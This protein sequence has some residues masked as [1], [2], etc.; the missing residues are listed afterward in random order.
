[1]SKQPAHRPHRRFKN[2][3][4]VILA[5]EFEQCIHCGEALELSGRAGYRR[6]PPGLLSF[7]WSLILSG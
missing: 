7:G 3:R 1:M 5:S 2:A 6:H 4:K